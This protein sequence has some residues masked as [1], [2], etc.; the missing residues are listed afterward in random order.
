[1]T[2]E[3]GRSMCACSITRGRFILAR[4]LLIAVLLGWF[5]ATVVPAQP[6]WDRVLR[7]GVGE[8]GIGG[9]NA[10]RPTAS[11][12][13]IRRAVARALV[14]VENPPDAQAEVVPDLAMSWSARANFAGWAFRIRRNARF[15]N[16]QEVQPED[17]V[18]SLRRCA[19]D[20]TLSGVD[21]FAL[22][23]RGDLVEQTTGQDPEWILVRT[24]GGK[25][26]AELTNEEKRLPPFLYDLAR[27]GVYPRELLMQFGSRFF[28]TTLITGAGRYRVESF[29][30]GKRVVLERWG[31]QVER[32]PRRI[33]LLQYS[34]PAAAIRQLQHGGVDLVLFD[35]PPTI[36]TIRGD[37]TLRELPCEGYTIIARRTV[38]ISCA[39]KL[40]LSEVSVTH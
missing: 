28:E 15:S 36:P 25:D 27:C 31:E 12:L 40:E 34:D 13:L 23:S 11:E 20:G 18:A 21:D 33:E 4:I 3:N 2:I 19:V 16:G 35:A 32:G 1:V 7:V 14:N 24:T 39:A 37:P 26:P 5:D 10:P 8:I 38:Q 29:A 17:V 9:G 30:L 6:V 22:S